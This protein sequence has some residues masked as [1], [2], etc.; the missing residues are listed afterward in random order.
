MSDLK[1]WNDFLDARILQ[2]K[3]KDTDALPILDRLCSEHPNTSA[4]LRAR[5][6]S[7]SVLNREEDAVSSVVAA[8]YAELAGKLRGDADIA[9]TWISELESLKD[10]INISSDKRIATSAVAW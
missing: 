1:A 9:E 4:F 2:E 7:L 3:R 6:W 5:A 10:A 8:K